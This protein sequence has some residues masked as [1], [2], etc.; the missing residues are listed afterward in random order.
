MTLKVIGES[1]TPKKDPIKAEPS[2]CL[3]CKHLMVQKHQLPGN[4]IPW[5]TTDESEIPE[6]VNSTAFI[7]TIAGVGLNSRE[8]ET[9]TN[10]YEPV[11]TMCNKFEGK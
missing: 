3:K 6:F 8:T 10:E 1:G 5:M 9:D 2:I 4:M 7:C 11:I